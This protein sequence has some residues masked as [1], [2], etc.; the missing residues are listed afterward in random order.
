MNPHHPAFATGLS[1]MAS[2]TASWMDILSLGGRT[3]IAQYRRAH[4][5]SQ[6]ELYSVVERYRHDFPHQWHLSSLDGSH[7]TCGLSLRN[8]HSFAWSTGELYFHVGLFNES[9]PHCGSVP[10][11]LTCGFRRNVSS[12]R[13]DK[14]PF[15]LVIASERSQ[16]SPVVTAVRGRGDNRRRRV[17]LLLHEA[18]AED[19]V[20]LQIRGTPE[21][22]GK[23]ENGATCRERV[24]ASLRHLPPASSMPRTA[25]ESCQMRPLCKPS[26]GRAMFRMPLRSGY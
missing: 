21:T 3:G 12:E 4:R 26:K 11:S 7:D 6:S 17:E 15:R 23:P 2:S 25:E 24:L 9:S 8:P 5:R 13:G 10:S 1:P 18:L 20:A 14:S 19:V 16:Y 22:P